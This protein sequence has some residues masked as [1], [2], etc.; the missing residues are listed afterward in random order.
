VSIL[1]FTKGL[2]IDNG[3]K[4]NSGHVNGR[5]APTMDADPY[6]KKK[7]VKQYIQCLDSY[8]GTTLYI[9]TQCAQVACCCS[10]T[11]NVKSTVQAALF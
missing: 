2:V 3:R 7:T 5:Y 9:R 4:P 8:C 1:F 10:P 11:Q 6:Q